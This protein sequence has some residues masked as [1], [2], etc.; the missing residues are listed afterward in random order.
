M[1]VR[2]AAVRGVRGV[3]PAELADI[4]RRMAE[5][6]GW[7]L[8]GAHW[9]PPGEVID[10]ARQGRIAPPAYTTDWSLTGPLME[11][12]IDSVETDPTED[13]GIVRTVT[14]LTGEQGQDPDIQVAFC[15]AY[16]ARHETWK[17]ER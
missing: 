13:G 5:A 16:L 2:Y 9:Y 1:P 8:V 7:R 10:Y 14:L 15:L 3:T 6:E 17:G 4:D 12:H 11:R